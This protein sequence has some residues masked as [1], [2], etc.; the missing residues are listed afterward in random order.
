[1][2]KKSKGKKEDEKGRRSRN[3]KRFSA[4]I[5]SCGEKIAVF[6]RLVR[7]RCATVAR[8]LW[9]F[10]SAVWKRLLCRFL[11]RVALP[12]GACLLALCLLLGTAVLILSAAVCDK[13]EER[14]LSLEELSRAEGEFDCI[15]VLGCRVYADGEPSPMLYDRV[16][17]GCRLYEAGVSDKILMSGDNQD[18]YYNE[19]DAMC[20]EAM[21]L[22][23]PED[24]IMTDRYGLSTYDSVVRALEEYGYRRVVIVTQ[25]YHLY[26]A[27][28][29]AE[30]LGVEAYGVSADLRPYYGQTKRDLREIL[31]RCKDVVYAHKRPPTI[32]ETQ[33]AELQ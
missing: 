14:I 29:I 21:E 3:D 5:R 24:A 2:P 33:L 20:R 16:V 26:R 23:V 1:M 19:I 15:L 12:V 18:V 28:Y 9:R 25:T 31:A 32:R 10:A 27:L 17:T 7:N 30:K 22:G 6:G 8:F 13:T 11:R 4:F